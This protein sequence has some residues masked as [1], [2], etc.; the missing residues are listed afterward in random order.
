MHMRTHTGCSTGMNYSVESSP[1]AFNVICWVN[2]STKQR[3]K[4]TYMHI[5]SPTC[6]RLSVLVDTHS[7]MHTHLHANAYIHTQLAHNKDLVMWTNT[8]QHACTQTHM[9]TPHTHS[10]THTHVHTTHTH[11]DLSFSVDFFFWSSHSSG[12]PVRH[13]VF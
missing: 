6:T 3:N 9:R 13:L 10:H 8:E 1:S 7:L 5:R 2:S 12:Y 11:T 4:D